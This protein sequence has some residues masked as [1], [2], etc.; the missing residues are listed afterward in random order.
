[1]NVAWPE[2]EIQ[3]SRQILTTQR[4]QKNFS[5]FLG[6]KARNKKGNAEQFVKIF[7]QNCNFYK[8]RFYK[9]I[10]NS[11]KDKEIKLGILKFWMQENAGLGLPL[12]IISTITPG[13]HPGAV[14]GNRLTTVSSI[15][16]PTDRQDLLK[17]PVKAQIKAI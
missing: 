17:A 3:F 9:A 2:K 10:F 5:P 15:G 8:L 14:L 12:Q 4:L 13:N 16:Y 6:G 7:T 11:K 1:V